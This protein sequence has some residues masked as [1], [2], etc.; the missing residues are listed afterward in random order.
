MAIHECLVTVSSG[1]TVDQGDVIAVRPHP[2]NWGRKEID[3]CLVILF[4]DDRDWAELDR[5]CNKPVL[6]NGEDYDD[7][8]QE[9]FHQEQDR[10]DFLNKYLIDTATDDIKEIAKKTDDIDGEPLTSEEK[11]KLKKF[12][13][14]ARLAADEAGVTVRERPKIKIMKPFNI[15]LDELIENASI[16]INP[17]KVRDKKKIYQPFK[18]SFQLVNK[19]NG[20]KGNHLVTEDEV[21]CG[22]VPE[23]VVMASSD[24]G[25]IFKRK[26]S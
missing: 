25:K 14:E 16:S 21:D 24:F 17:T 23:E 19:F 26:D 1:W 5:M 2:W 11:D 9:V 3:N 4:E 10:M 22:D 6:E 20:E 13:E 8:E 7:V 12:S 18:N 15:N